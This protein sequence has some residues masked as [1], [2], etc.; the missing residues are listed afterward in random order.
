MSKIVIKSGFSAVACPFDNFKSLEL[1][2]KLSQ[3]GHIYDI[4]EVREPSK[5]TLVYSKCVPQTNV[6]G[7]SGHCKH[8]AALVITLNNHRDESQTDN[9]QAWRKPS[10]HGKSLYPKGKRVKEIIKSK[11]RGP[12]PS[13]ALPSKKIRAH[14]MKDLEEFGHANSQI[15]HELKEEQGR[16]NLKQRGAWQF[17]IGLKTSYPLSINLSRR[18]P[19]IL[20]LCHLNCGNSTKNMC[21]IFEATLEQSGSVMWINQRKLRITGSRAHGIFRGRTPHT[22]AGNFFKSPPE[23]ESIK[24]GRR[25]EKAALDQYQLITKREVFRP[26]LVI[27]KVQPWLATTP[28]GFSLMKKAT[29]CL[30]N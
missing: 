25:M 1:G 15:Y 28:D 18:P 6:T 22:R 7:L 13:Y 20:R 8:R 17:R 14:Y 21:S 4:T 9:Q 16:S 23:V 12:S 10:T 3:A 5:E 19:F 11:S 2:Q 26:G 27:K 30:G 24:Y 29:S